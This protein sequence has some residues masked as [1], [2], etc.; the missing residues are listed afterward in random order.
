MIESRIVSGVRTEKMSE[1]EV[2]AEFRSLLAAGARIRPAGRAKSRPGRLLSAG[3][4]P[5]AKLRLF[6]T[7]FYLP[8]LRQEPNARFFV[9]YVMLGADRDLP[10]RR[11][12]LF[13]RYFYKDASLVWRSASHF[14][15]SATENWIGK[16]DL[17]WVK[18][19]RGLAEYTAE[20]TTNLP[21]E[22]QPALD[23][24]S[25][26]TPVIVRDDRAIGLVL[27]QAPDDRVEPY[28]DFVAAR[29]KAQANRRNLVNGG[30]PVAWF[31]RKND[32]GSLRFASG[33][34]PDFARG[35]VEESRVGSKLYGGE[36]RKLRILSVNRRI[37]YQ[38][39]LGPRHA[40]IVPPQTLTT[41]LSSFGVRTIDVDADDDLCVPG[42][43]YHYLDESC[44]PP[45]MYSQIPPGFA[46]EIS[47][48]DPARADAS[49]WLE[50]LPV[51]QAFRRALG[52][53]AP[54]PGAN[55]R[56]SPAPK[57]AGRRA[58]P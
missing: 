37:Q 28:S 58:S 19:D 34:E 55:A 4:V 42:L 50:A 36:L 26:E 16:G 27:R 17:K 56:T 46:G 29:R 51:I 12:E 21:F 7:V 23:V 41:E 32:P 48:V 54:R 18:E 15:R 31:T 30:K 11:R 47:E 45:E 5:R 38:F 9:A 1:A 14:A 57:R 10:A 25:R 43:E 3:Y 13:P 39:V 33:F 53:P 6:D 20:E 2:E 40:W 24:L 44:D 49:P 52:V 22:L 35:I 8:H